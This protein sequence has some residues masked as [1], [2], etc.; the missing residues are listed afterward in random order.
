MT[1]EEAVAVLGTD[2][3]GPR[4]KAFEVFFGE[5]SL[6]LAERE[7]LRMALE[8]IA[9]QQQCPDNLMSNVDIANA[10]LAGKARP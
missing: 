10:A 4:L 3:T 2:L 9:G 7:R 8:M 5:Y 6:L 1:P